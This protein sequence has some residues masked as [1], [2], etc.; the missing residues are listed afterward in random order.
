MSG[1][2]SRLGD[3]TSE[4]E[5][6]YPPNVRLCGYHSR[7]GPFKE[8]NV[9]PA[10]IRTPDLPAR[11]TDTTPNTLSQHDVF[12][13]LPRFLSTKQPAKCGKR[14]DGSAA[15]NTRNKM[16]RFAFLFNLVKRALTGVFK[17]NKSQGDTVIMDN[18]M[19]SVADTHMN[20]KLKGVSLV[21]IMLLAFLTSALKH[22]SVWS[23]ANCGPS[24]RLI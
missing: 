9:Y 23:A 21:K 1:S 20:S 10:E 6:R 5:P 22:A 11:N 2:T 12:L 3:F 24:T 16:G 8:E 13:Q 15:T 7:S 4:E 19:L 17:R 18:V 14:H